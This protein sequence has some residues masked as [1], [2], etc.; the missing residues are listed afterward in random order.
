MRQTKW[1]T[2]VALALIALMLAACGGGATPTTAP[3]ATEAPAA[4]TAPAA[5]EAPTA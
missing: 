5:T 4:T 1:F 2:L 3:V